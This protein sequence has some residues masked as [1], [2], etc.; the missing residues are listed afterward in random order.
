MLVQAG[1]SSLSSKGKGISAAAAA[2]APK[3]KKNVTEF[4]DASK[5]KLEAIASSEPVKIPE[6]AVTVGTQQR[7]LKAAL[8]RG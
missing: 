8:P 6:I 3:M 5:A 4:T 2:A 7:K 1:L